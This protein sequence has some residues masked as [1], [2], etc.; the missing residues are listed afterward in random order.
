MCHQRLRFLAIVREWKVVTGLMKGAAL[1]LFQH[2]S[3][4]LPPTVWG[5]SCSS[6]AF[7]LFQYG[8]MY[9][10]V[11]SKYYQL[12]NNHGI[13]LTTFGPAPYS[14]EEEM[15]Y[16]PTCIS[17]PGFAWRR[18]VQASCDVISYFYLSSTEPQHLISLMS[19]IFM[20]L[21]S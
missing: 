9:S 4:I 21:R 6:Y 14:H 8:R 16:L 17:G 13:I 12:S 2:S 19:N 7:Y 18:P 20:L 1:H 10:R 11:L 5:V 15:V 3:F